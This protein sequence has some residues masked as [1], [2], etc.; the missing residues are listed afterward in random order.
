MQNTT[1]QTASQQSLD[2]LAT[3]IGASLRQQFGLD[4]SPADVVAILADSVRD[5]VGV[6]ATQP[7]PPTPRAQPPKASV[8]TSV[9]E[10]VRIARDEGRQFSVD[11]V[12]GQNRV[13]STYQGKVEVLGSFTGQFAKELAALTCTGLPV[14]VAFATAAKLDDGS[15]ALVSVKQVAQDIQYTDARM[16]R[17]TVT[18][19]PVAAPAIAL[20]DLGITQ[21]SRW[22]EAVEFDTG[23]CLVSGGGV[24]STL[25]ATAAHLADEGRKVVWV[26]GV[27][28]QADVAQLDAD[29]YVFERKLREPSVTNVVLKLAQSALVLASCALIDLHEAVEFLARCSHSAQIVDEVLVAALRQ[30]LFSGDIGAND[31]PSD[32]VLATECATFFHEED[33][34]NVLQGVYATRW[35]GIDVA[36]KVRSNQLSEQAARAVFPEE[37]N[38]YF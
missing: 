20:D 18:A 8:L 12:G 9:H 25:R 1:A 7:T 30:H 29:V 14:D 2:S 33:T 19:A 36:E 23:L 28:P 6:T 26:W 13:A 3:R 38:V 17:F 27:G 32:P 21:V 11:V 15:Y 16:H 34:L 5:G 10:M 24:H 37:M 31:Q 35:L 22:R 4:I